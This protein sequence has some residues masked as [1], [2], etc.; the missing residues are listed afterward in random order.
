MTVTPRTQAPEPCGLGISTALTGGGKYDPELIRF[1]TL[2]RLSARSA[3]NASRSCPPTPGAPLLALTRRHASQT[4]DLATTNGLASDFGM[5]ARF[6]PRPAG[7]GLFDRTSLLSRPLG[8]IATP[9]SSGFTATTGRSASERRVGTQCLRY[10]PLAGSLSRP[11]RPTTPVAISTLA[12]SRSVQEP[13]TRLT[14]PPRRAPP[15]RCIG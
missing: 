3:S 5:F 10:L 13:Q 8:S 12:F 6:L 4:I 15:G 2:K 9:A 11:W 1:Q 14:P 7:P